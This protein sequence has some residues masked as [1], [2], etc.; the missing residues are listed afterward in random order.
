MMTVKQTLSRS[1]R[2][3]ADRTAE[4]GRSDSPTL[5]EQL[6]REQVVRPYAAGE[7]SSGTWGGNVLI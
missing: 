2:R 6:L 3:D 1:H 5:Y 7:A 4:R